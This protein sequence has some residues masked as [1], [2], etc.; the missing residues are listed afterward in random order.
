MRFKVYRP[1][2]L[3]GGTRRFY[4]LEII[5]VMHGAVSRC[6]VEHSLPSRVKCVTA[7]LL[8]L[9]THFSFG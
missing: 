7:Y 1:I 2:Q 9:E 8:V 5:R 4:T 3:L 6:L